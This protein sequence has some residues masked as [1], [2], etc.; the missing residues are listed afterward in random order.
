MESFKCISHVGKVKTGR[1]NKKQKV[2]N[3]KNTNPKIFGACWFPQFQAVV[4]NLGYC[5]TLDLPF[6]TTSPACV[7]A[8][9]KVPSYD[10]QAVSAS[11]R[12][13]LKGG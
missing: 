8:T 1:T 12:S 3:K 11:L 4:A 6:G 5:K 2:R 10:P 9:K 13:N 7:A